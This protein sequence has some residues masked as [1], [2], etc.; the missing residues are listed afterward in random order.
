MLRS[1]RVQDYTVP[2]AFALFVVTMSNLTRVKG[3]YVAFGQ[4]GLFSIGLKPF[5]KTSD[6]T[7]VSQYNEYNNNMAR[8]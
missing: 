3:A 2:T 4:S 1:A 5:M 8:H 6:I 7:V